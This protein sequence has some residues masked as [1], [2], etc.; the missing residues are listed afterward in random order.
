MSEFT[1][2]TEKDYQLYISFFRLM[3]YIALNAG[4][5]E[6]VNRDLKWAAVGAACSTYDEF[7]VCGGTRPDSLPPAHSR[8]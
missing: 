8:M 4:T 5:L 3:Y 6:K 1:D 2:F 7:E